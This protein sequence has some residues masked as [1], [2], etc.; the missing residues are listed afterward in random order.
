MSY[1]CNLWKRTPG[2]WF[3]LGFL[4]NITFKV[5]IRIFHEI[6][7]FT[8]LQAKMNSKVFICGD[9][10]HLYN[11]ASVQNSKSLYLWWTRTMPVTM[12][13]CWNCATNHEDCMQQRYI[14]MIK[15]GKWYIEK[16]TLEITT[17]Q[18]QRTKQCCNV[19]GQY[20]KQSLKS[21]DNASNCFTT[22]GFNM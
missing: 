1:G 15:Q 7:T 18:E 9:C 10:C 19:Q 12:Q 21:M 13:K 22:Q 16:I 8:P 3:N 17:V 5:A 20:R 14:D 2:Y 6:I 11:Y 4:I